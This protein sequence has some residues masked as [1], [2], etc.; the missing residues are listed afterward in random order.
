MPFQVSP[1]INVS[2]IDLTTI[3]P[4]VATTVGGIAGYYEWGPADRVV[5]IDTPNNY[6][7]TFGD[8]KVWNYSQWFTGT[9]FL[10]YGRSLLV[11]RKTK[12]GAKN[13]VGSSITYTATGA[14]NGSLTGTIGITFGSSFVSGLTTTSGQVGNKVFFAPGTADAST[15]STTVTG[16]M[17]FSLLVRS[18]D[19][20]FVSFE[21]GD[22]AIGDISPS[23]TSDVYSFTTI[24]L[25]GYS[26]VDDSKVLTFFDNFDYFVAATGN[27]SVGYTGATGDAFF[28][29][30]SSVAGTV[31]NSQT[32]D[33]ADVTE[34]HSLTWTVGAGAFV[35]TGPTNQTRYIPNSSGLTS[36]DYYGVFA[37]YPGEKGDSLKVSLFLGGDA[38]AYELWTWYKD[39]NIIGEA[40]SAEGSDNLRRLVG[41]D[42]NDLFHMVVVDEDGLFTGERNTV[43]ERYAN[44][45]LFPQS[46][47]DNGTINYYKSIINNASQYVFIGGSETPEDSIDDF[48]KNFGF[49]DGLITVTETYKVAYPAFFNAGASANFSVDI[50]LTGG[51]GSGVQTSVNT[52]DLIDTVPAGSD[53]KGYN[54]FEDTESVNVSLVMAGAIDDSTQLSHLRALAEQ[55]KDCVVFVSSSNK[56]DSQTENDKKNACI[57]TKNNVGSSSYVFIDSGYKYQYDQYN[58][59]YRWIP[60]N[61]DTAGLVARADLT[62]DPWFSPAGLNR[63][64]IR[65]AVKLAFNPSQ[66]LRDAIYPKG[67]NP[68]ISVPGEGTILFGD[69]TALSKPSAFDRINVRRLFIVLEKA[70]A[71][72]SKFS[73]FEFNDAF[74]RQQFKNLVEPFL[75]D[76]KARRGIFDWKVVC[77]ETNN[78]PEMIDRNEFAADIYIKPTRTINFIQL[79]F[80]ATR[81]GV[82]FDEVGA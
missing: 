69:R 51:T 20:D 74:T 12:T 77:D 3:V 49:T 47:T 48:E 63:G 68:V 34:N 73:L 50:S 9:N 38:N 17:Y 31:A 26:V 57:S 24:N 52:D 41:S 79:N 7:K 4:A 29:F 23:H 67:I 35:G 19:G 53:P 64:Q 6:R 25:G 40:P 37:K 76:V 13:A 36:S 62:N 15:T 66:T 30:D 10:G 43:L 32:G 42:T 5:L 71:A 27:G 45:S 72:A 11:V 8:P 54:L 80:I 39:Q 78:T 18:I 61:G 33:A 44:V 2:E 22:N 55:R 16:P 56:D 14:I 75:R 58:D 1:G 65:N 82:S 70:I 28:E 60:L 59:R 81:T 21:T 46:R